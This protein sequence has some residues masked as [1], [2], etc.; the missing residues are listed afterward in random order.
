[1]AIITLHRRAETDYVMGL[2]ALDNADAD[3][4]FVDFAG[5][6]LQQSVEKLLK[7]QLQSR[8]VKFPYKHDID[9]LLDIMDDDSNTYNV[10]DWVREHAHTLTR[11]EAQTRY[12][13]VKI[14]SKGLLR[15]LYVNQKEFIDSLRSNNEPVE[16]DEF[17]ASEQFS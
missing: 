11:Y 17:S 16:D 13:S 7:F 8:G 5:Y 14:A 9:L 4:T 6:T 3:D 2:N 15:R 12:S 1:M 10:P